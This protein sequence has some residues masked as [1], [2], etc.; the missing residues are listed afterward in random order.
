MNM[1]LLLIAF[2]LTKAIWTVAQTVP[3]SIATWKNN[4]EGAYNLIHDDFGDQGVIGINNY[5]DT[6]AFNR[7]IKITFGA[8]TRSC[9]Q[10]PS[11]YAKANEMIY[12]H[13]HEI[14]NHSHTHSCAVTNNNCGGTGDNYGWGEVATQRLNIEVDSSSK[15]IL[16]NT[17]IQPRYFIYPYDQ[18]SANSDNYLKTKGYIGARTGTYNA[19]APSTFNPD[20]DGFFKTALVVDVQNQ[21][22]SWVSVNHNFW[23]DQAINNNSWVNRE[24]HNVGPTGWGTISVANYRT[25]LNYVKQKM[26]TGELWVGTVSEILTYQIQKLNYTPS[27]TYN[28]TSKVISVTWNTPTFDVANYLLPLQFKSPITLNVNVVNVPGVYKII[29]NGVEITEWSRSGNMISVNIYPHLGTV[30]LVENTCNSVCIA[31]HPQSASLIE[32]SNLN[33]GVAATGVGN[34]SYQ[35]YKNNQIING[36][37]NSTYVVNNVSIADTG[38]YYVTIT[39]GTT[40]INSNVAQVSVTIQAPFEG[41]RMVIPGKIEAERFDIGGQNV[42]YNESTST[43]LGDA[44]SFRTGPVDI[45]VC[46]DAGGGNNI[47]YIT[48]GEWLEYSVNITSAGIYNLQMRIAS[49]NIGQPVGRVS[50]DL[51]GSNIL[52]ASNLAFTGGWQTWQNVSFNNITLPAG[53]HLLRITAVAGDFNFNFLNTI[54]VTPLSIETNE[55]IKPKVNQMLSPF[56]FPNPAL[57]H[58]QIGGIEDGGALRY[59]IYDFSNRLVKSG[60]LKDQTDL[61]SIAGLSNGIYLMQI[62]GDYDQAQLKFVKE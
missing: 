22:G 8:I 23:V 13:G 7:G 36:A 40:T 57:N 44:P 41:V 9:E 42:S 5:A 21:S 15:S 38:K 25:H 49:Q 53:N 46:T 39:N 52:P 60:E 51:D 54:L 10:N 4:A 19:A 18:F 2:V 30:T 45:E 29:Q 55:A 43:N 61:I 47:G 27:S 35:W 31:S 1:R 17:G 3:V 20:V 59:K 50:I 24:M 26:N 56:L 48:N 14:I 32:G 58:V 16:K 6:M 37:Q 28:P 34:L 62:Q 33:L 11:M 12:D